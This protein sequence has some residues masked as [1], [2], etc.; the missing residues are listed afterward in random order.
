MVTRLCA[1]FDDLHGAPGV[2]R[3]FGKRLQKQPLADV[4]GTRAGDQDPPGFN[5]RSARRLISL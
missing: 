4:V 3:G 1:L 5:N 2:A